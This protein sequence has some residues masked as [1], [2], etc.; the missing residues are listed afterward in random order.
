MP[1][2][3]QTDWIEWQGGEC[4]VDP[5]TRVQIQTADGDPSWMAPEGHPAGIF[6][7]DSGYLNCD[8]WLADNTSH[9]WRII[10]YRVV[11]A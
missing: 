6:C 8:W 9:A 10:A 2:E 7:D 5:D 4:P 11:Q 1:Q 3:N